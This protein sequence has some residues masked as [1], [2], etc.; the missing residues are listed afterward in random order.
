MNAI[1]LLKQ[2]HDEVKALFEKF[3]KA[4][5]DTER[6]SVCQKIANNLVA[7]MIIEERIFYPAAFSAMNDEAQLSK[8]TSEHD[9]TKQLL[10]TILDND[11]S[12]DQ[13]NFQENMR[14][15]KL[16]LAQHIAE[17]EQGVFKETRK[18]LSHDQLTRLG[19]QMKDLFDQE[20]AGEP[21]E[22]L[23]DRPLPDGG[24]D[25]DAEFLDD[26][27]LE[28]DTDQDTDRKNAPL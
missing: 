10:A 3:D 14:E 27:D 28:A 15:L 11:M 26:D 23:S 16:M 6:D 13:D 24:M 20:M 8:S 1:H 25:E 18:V 12:R 21:S 5:D 7:H 9:A 4:D 19:E 22:L 17:E 2:Q